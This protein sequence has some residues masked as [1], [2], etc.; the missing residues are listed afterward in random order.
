MLNAY[1]TF[2]RTGEKEIVIKRSRFIGYGAP[3][4]SEEE[5]IAFIAEIR[6]KHAQASHNCFAYMIGERDQIQRFSDDG[7]P[8]GTAGKPILE[9]LKNQGLQNIAVVVTRYFGGT[10]L[11]AGGLVRAYTDGAVAASEAAEPVDQV[12]HRLVRVKVDY[13]WLGKLENELRLRETLLDETLYADLVTLQCLPREDDHE[14]FA[15]W[16]TDL[17]Q[18]QGEIEI[19]DPRYV[20][21]DVISD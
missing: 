11:G 10:M 4:E 3:V 15:A 8:S 17:T 13:T 21:H 12:L 19:G 18:G 2:S 7:E 20:P 5:A 16:M 9:V 6:K 1:R 14:A